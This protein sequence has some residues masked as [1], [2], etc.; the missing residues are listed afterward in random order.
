MDSDADSHGGAGPVDE[1]AQVVAAHFVRAKR[2]AGQIKGKAQHAV[3]IHSVVWKGGDQVGEYRQKQE[4]QNDCQTEYGQP[5]AQEP[6][7][8]VMPQC[9]VAVPTRGRYV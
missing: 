2:M 4:D 9:P 1:T 7:G 8:R 5:V 6:S 3:E